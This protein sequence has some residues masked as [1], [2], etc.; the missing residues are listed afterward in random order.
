MEPR[1]P[2]V[3]AMGAVAWHVRKPHLVA[4]STKHR[5]TPRPPSGVPSKP[6]QRV[7]LPPR[8]RHPRLDGAARTPVLTRPPPPCAEASFTPFP[9]RVR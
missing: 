8:T 6:A 4:G 3:S 7:P 9:P 5:S 2:R 1:V